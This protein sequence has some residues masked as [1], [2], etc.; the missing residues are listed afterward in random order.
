M[1]H[2]QTTCMSAISLRLHRA[3]WES[4][5]VLLLFLNIFCVC[6]KGQILKIRLQLGLLSTLKK[7]RLCIHLSF[8]QL[9]QTHLV[10]FMSFNFALSKINLNVSS[11]QAIPTSCSLHL[12]AL[13]FINIG[14]PLHAQVG[15]KG[16]E[17]YYFEVVTLYLTANQIDCCSII[18]QY[19]TKMSNSKIIHL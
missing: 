1:V 3:T 13:Y 9:H 14:R 2:L 11:F 6:G 19:R 17:T 15:E 5:F 18:E 7:P 12:M 10:L 4:D 8:I 16:F